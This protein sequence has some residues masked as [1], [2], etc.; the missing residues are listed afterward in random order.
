MKNNKQRGFTLIELIVVMVIIGMLA[1]FMAF[2]F[3]QVN[4]RARDGQRKSDLQQMRSALELYRS[5][6]STSDYPA[7]TV[8]PGGD[9]ILV[10]C[11]TPFTSGSTTYMQK[12]PCDPNNAS[13]NGGDYYYMRDAV[14]SYKY[15]IVACLENAKDG[16]DFPSGL[17]A[18][19]GT[20]SSGK[21]YV[22]NN[23]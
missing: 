9:S 8:T 22:L 3:I 6:S 11:G 5:D 1:S 10:A 15:T 7:G 16:E 14:D 4:Q 18:P 12:I 17:T 19:P 2:N 13:W 20:C 23:P 21:Y